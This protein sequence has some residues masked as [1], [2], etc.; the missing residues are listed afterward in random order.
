MKKF[1]GSAV[2]MLVVA[3]CAGALIYRDRIE[4]VYF[5]TRLF[6]GAEQ[7]ETFPILREIFPTSTMPASDTPAPFPTGDPLQL[8][9]TFSFRGQSV[10][11]PNFLVETDTVALLVVQD[12]K[13]RFEK[14]WLTGG[15]STH[16]LS[17]SVAKSF[18]SALVGIAVAEGTIDS[19]EEPITRYVPELTGSAY[20]GVRIKDVLQMSSG[21]RWNEDYSD[22]NSD[23]NRFGRVFA[24]GGS[25]NAFAATLTR[26]HPPGTFGRYNSADTQALGML[27]VNAT[28]K[29]LTTYMT[30]K[31]WAPMGA[32]STGHWLLDDEGMELAFA[33]LNAT[34]RDYA[35]LGEIYRRDGQFNGKQIVPEAWVGDSLT[36]D[37]AHLMPGEDNPMFFGL[38]YGYQWWIPESLEGE[39]SA[40]GVYNQF[41]F[42]N[43]TA[44]TVIVKLSANSEYGLT[45]TEESYREHETIEFFRA[46]TRDLTET[47]PK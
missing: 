22:P 28:G 26:E 46:I 25:A 27:L 35:K 2:A 17:M 19:I 43:P 11:V 9:E 31:I 44:R 37:A 47:V 14:Y 18:V 15:S 10:S 16:W 34:A 8:P 30:E 12:G 13:I 40:I 4:R 23:V 29:P 33:G 24:L 6:S 41:I 32:E 42:V 5:A 20:E 21:A 45:N 39:F 1:I 36:P 38:G 3:V 7:Y